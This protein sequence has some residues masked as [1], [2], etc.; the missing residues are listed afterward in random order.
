[1]VSVAQISRASFR[2]I[3]LSLI[4]GM[5][6]PAHSAV[7]A[8]GLAAPPARTLDFDI[9]HSGTVVGHYHTDFVETGDNRLEA[10]TRI[11]AEVKA[12]PIRLYHY[13]HHSVEVWQ[14]GRLMSLASDTD[15]DGD[16]HHVAVS[17][18]LD[19][20]KLA[21]DG[22]AA[23]PTDAA[24]VPSSLWN[25]AMVDSRR[26]VIDISD[27]EV[28]RTESNCAMGVAPIATTCQVRGGFQRNLDYDGN[29]VLLGLWFPADDGSKV[30]Y[31]RN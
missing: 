25:R 21:V 15:D 11:T 13:S 28:M 20:L 12:G 6:L 2:L 26:P 16:V 9:V 1:M 7:M 10:R 23:I 18:D 22:K 17:R 8:G 31:R 19:V 4:L 24:A 30:M 14:D 27:G 29:G 3:A 5:S